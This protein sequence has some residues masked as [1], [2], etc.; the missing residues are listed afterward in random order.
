MPPEKHKHVKEVIN[1]KQMLI[2]GN[3]EKDVHHEEDPE[4]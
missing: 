3:H 2:P 4:P 1:K